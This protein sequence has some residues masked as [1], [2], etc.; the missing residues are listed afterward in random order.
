MTRVTIRICGTPLRAR[1]LR[2]KGVPVRVAA[3]F[4]GR[5]P[6]MMLSIYDEATPEHLDA[7]MRAC[8]R[9]V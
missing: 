4:L 1:E 3:D 6:G 2:R 8:L 7:A 5:S 9:D